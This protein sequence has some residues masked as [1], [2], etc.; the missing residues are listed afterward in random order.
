MLIYLISAV[1]AAITSL[2]L[3]LLQQ[4]MINLN[5]EASRQ[6]TVLT[7]GHNTCFLATLE[8]Q[9]TTFL[10]QVDTGSSDTVLP[11]SSL[12]SYN[13]PAVNYTIPLLATLV[14]QSY[15]DGSYWYGLPITL[16]VT[17]NGTLLSAPNVPIGLMTTQSTMPIFASGTKFQGLM[18]IA[19]PAL[20][21]NK[22]PPSGIMDAWV[23][24]KIIAKNQ[25]AFHGCPYSSISNAWIDFGNETPYI[26]CRGIVASIMMPSKSYYNID[27]MNI[28]INGLDI[29]LPSTF[30][31]ANS[32]SFMDSC[33]SNIMLP[34]NSLAAL[35]AAIKQSNAIS[36]TWTTSGYFDSWLASQVQLPF[37][38]SDINW[39]LLPNI[40][41]TI[42]THA[43]DTASSVT[44]VL[45]PKHYI[46]ANGLGY[47]TF[48]VGSWGSQYAILGLPFF[49]AFHVV[50]DKDLGK[51]T[52]QLGCDCESSTDGY[53]KII[54]QGKTIEVAPVIKIASEYTGFKWPSKLF[55]PYVN[56]GRPFDLVGVSQAVGSI[57]YA[58]GFINSGSD[59]GATW[60][61][62]LPVS[63]STHSS[64]LNSLRLFGGDVIASFG[65]PIG[66]YLFYLRYRIGYSLSVC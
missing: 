34:Q 9:N 55:A 42:N 66:N 5:G 60:N 41:F 57:N 47:Y 30:Q 3:P 29:P 51:M 35:K 56:T 1:Q 13:G 59:G 52:F 8:V 37:L 38:D 20:S 26:G 53:P 63:N 17:L 2:Q 21:Y 31:S 4:P 44:L 28:G 6:K 12:N 39:N 48:M 16:N 49:S 7:G 54:T 64:E 32:W 46:Q 58:L 62:S 24:S 22:N 25:I 27:L 45:G 50:V 11:H 14:S 36:T 10:V 33:T 23:D 18:G 15:G 43:F 40:T 61:S 19:F 65:G